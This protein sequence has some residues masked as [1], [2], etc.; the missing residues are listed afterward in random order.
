MGTEDFVAT[1]ALYWTAALVTAAIDLVFVPL[2][3]W[4]VQRERFRQ[5]K[6]PLLGVSLIFWVALW[7][8]VVLGCWDWAYR[9]VFPGWGRWVIPPLYGLIFGVMGIAFW[10]IALRLP[11]SPVVTFCILGGLQ[12]VPGHLWAI[13]KVGMLNK[14]PILK[15]VSPSSAL[16]FGLFEFIF[17]WAVIVSIAALVARFS[18]RRSPAKE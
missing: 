18:P 12:S 6:W 7:T 11:V 2:L 15:D 8:T 13:Y 5:L 3:A 17:Y 10:W 4:R 9:Y 14:V 16:A 1:S